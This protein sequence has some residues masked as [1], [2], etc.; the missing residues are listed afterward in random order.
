MSTCR[1]C[2][3]TTQQIFQKRPVFGPLIPESLHI[4]IA[5]KVPIRDL[6]VVGN[7]RP[8]RIAPRPTFPESTGIAFSDLIFM[9]RPESPDIL[10][11]VPSFLTRS[12]AYRAVRGCADAGC[13]FLPPGRFET[14]I[15]RV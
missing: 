7:V 2:K 3:P 10:E 14:F 4:G 1:H 9:R 12:P 11:L 6:P 5:L 8:L 13:G 15:V